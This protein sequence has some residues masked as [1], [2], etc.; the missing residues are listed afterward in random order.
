MKSVLT[1]SGRL[2]KEFLPAVY[3]DSSVVIDYWM[4][5]GM[6]CPESETQKLISSGEL[7]YLKVVRDILRS[8]RRVNEV[9]EIR[10]KLVS[11]QPKA[12][13]VVSPIC[14]VELIEWQAEAGFRQIA[15]EACG[16]K[17]VQKIGKKDI[18]EYVKK[19]I[20]LR[21]DEIKQQEERG[22]EHPWSTGLESLICA[23][24]PNQSFAECHGL[25]GILQLDVVNFVLTFEN[26]W[27]K[28]SDYASLQ[29]GVGDIMHI[30]LGQHFGCKYI[31]SFDSDFGR[32]KEIIEG[33]TGMVV[34]RSV[35]E[36]LDVL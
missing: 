36:I 28:C 25:S 26:A 34:L 33:E 32:A 11:G 3:F 16:A 6:E 1:N 35:K 27:V 15:S 18:G 10:R 7:P 13:P 24:W 9:V 20:A 2:Q 21:K 4:T 23:I 5:E 8:E 22:K 17:F 30:L 19:T 12:T 31:A 14:L 29:L